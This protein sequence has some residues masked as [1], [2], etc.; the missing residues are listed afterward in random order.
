MKKALNVTTS[1]C[2]RAAVIGAGNMG[3]GIAAQFANAGVEVDLLDIPAPED[4]NAR[5]K[6]GI[7][8]QVKNR[9]FMGKAPVKLVRPGNVEDDFGWL[10]EADWIIEAVIEDL[11]IKRALFDRIEPILK[12]GAVASSNT[13]TIPR[14]KLIEGRSQAFADAFLIS[15]FFNPPRYMELLE[16]VGDPTSQAYKFAARAGEDVLGKTVVPCMDSPGF[17]A[18]RIGCTWIAVAIVEAIRLGL[19]VEEADAVQTAFGVPRTGVFGLMDLVGIDLIPAIWGSLMSSL[20]QADM[21]NQFDLPAQQALV[22]MI[23]AGQHGRKTGAGF[24]RK[25]P[26][27]T[28]EAIDLATGTY[29]AQKR[30]TAKDLPGKGNWAT[31]MQDASVLGQYA[32]S[33]VEGVMTYVSDHTADIAFAPAD[34]DAAMKLGYAW[35]FGPF[36]L[37]ETLSKAEGKATTTGAVSGSGDGSRLARARAAGAKVAGN[38]SASVWNIGEGLLALELHTRM[39]AVDD[40]V[41]DT[42]DAAL[43]KLSGDAKALV[44]GN[45]NPR[46]FS[47]GANLAAIDAMIEAEDW[48]ALD[49]FSAK[50]QSL[51][52][53]LRTAPAPVVAAVTGVALGGGCELVLHSD[54]AVLHAEAQIGLPESTLGLLP[55]WGGT[56]RVLSRAQ[57]QFCTKGPAAA[58]NAAAAI[59]LAKRPFGSAREAIEAGLLPETV[60]IAMHRNAVF[61]LAVHR[62]QELVDG[63]EPPAAA[64][65]HC[66]GLSALE[67]AMTGFVTRHK[68][69]V[70]S[71][72]DMLIAEK[73][74]KVLTGGDNADITREMDEADLLA[75]ERKAFVAMAGTAVARQRIGK[76]L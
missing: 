72:E 62:A 6:S 10:A 44:I 71:D 25:S 30:V 41:L 68:A 23:E 14:E 50:G 60:G 75:L 13:S 21:I 26:D 65:F 1:G 34:I 56:T 73:V 57:S 35:K 54:D 31:L 28:R 32:K 39:N 66:P 19:T 58:V 20:P 70:L 48:D 59:V 7:A 12:P 24:Y 36:E 55:A 33:V 40:G 16:L 42:I 4:R 46:A 43:N 51:Y 37:M 38:D 63:Y 3:A 53:A 49:A 18:N 9:G 15:H 29:R 45:D 22:K 52:A 61:D 17:I 67:G 27:G 64:V 2:L 8:N 11:E 74:L 47:A 69:G 5:A 76:L